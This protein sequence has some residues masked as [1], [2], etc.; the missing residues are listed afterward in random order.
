MV[1]GMCKSLG[2]RKGHCLCSMILFGVI[3]FLHLSA[4][5]RNLHGRHGMVMKKPQQYFVP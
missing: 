4:R 2:H 1:R 5:A 3:L